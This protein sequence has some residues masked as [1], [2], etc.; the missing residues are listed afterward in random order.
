MI[1][2]RTGIRLQKADRADAQPTLH[3][4]GRTGQ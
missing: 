2:G 1:R 4:R 3:Y